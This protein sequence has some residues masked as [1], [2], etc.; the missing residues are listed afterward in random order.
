MD[1]KWRNDVFTTKEAA[2]M[3]HVSIPTLYRM[4]RAGILTPA[5]TKLNAGGS[6]VIPRE[7]IEHYIE[8]LKASAR[9]RLTPSE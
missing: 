8:S 6:R 3:L 5:D 7:E 9:R 2:M 1:S 4:I